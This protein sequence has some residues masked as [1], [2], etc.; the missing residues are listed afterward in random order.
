MPLRFLFGPVTTA[1]AEENL[2][3]FRE[4]GTC[5]AFGPAGTSDISI[6]PGE[7]WDAVLA[8]LPESWRP[9]FVALWLPYATIP[10]GL[11]SAPVPLVGLAADW[12]L[13]WHQYRRCLRRC[14]LVLTDAAGVDVMRRAGIT[15]VRAADLFGCE[16]S[17]LE[18]SLLDGPRDIDIL[19]VGNV[20]SAV[21][22][23]RLAWLG[24]LARLSERRRVAI[25]TSIH[26]ADYRALLRRAK[27]VFNRSIRGECNR[28]VFEAAAS[29]ALLFQEAGNREV[30]AY[31]RDRQE[32]VYYDEGNLEALLEHYLAH[33]DERL[34]IAAAAREK[35]Q[36]FRFEDFW[37]ATLGRVEEDW[38]EVA[39]RS[40]QRPAFTDIEDV[41]DRTWQCLNSG[42]PAADPTL[43]RDLAAALT[44]H[45][46]LAALHN[47]LGLVVAQSAQGQGPITPAVAEQAVGY[48][49]RAVSCNPGHV[50]A[51]LNVAEALLGIG[52][53]EEAV[54]QARKTLSALE[55]SQNLDAS[56]LDSG[57]FPP[58]FDPFR[59]EWERAAWLN[60]G[61]PAEEERAKRDLLRW[62]LNLLLTGLTG[63][64]THAFEAVLARPDLPSSRVEL[65]A[66]LAQ[67]GRT[68]EALPHLRAAV[69]ANPFDVPAARALFQALGDAED[70]H[71]QRFLARDRR[72]LAQA[73]PQ[74]V[75]PEPWFMN[76]PPVGDEL[77]SILILCCNEVEY[78]RQCLESVFRHT[79]RPY[80]LILVDNGSSDRTP[81]YLDEVS[82][83][84]GPDRV[85]VLRNDTNRGFPAGCNQ[86]LAQVQGRYV[87]FLN[88]DTIVTE[89]WLDGLIRWSLNEWPKIGLVG[90]VTNYAP[91]PQHVGEDPG[92]LDVLPA[93]A[94]RRQR[95]YAG[96][97]LE[98]ERLSGFCLLARR[99][100]LQQIGGFDERFGLGFFDD[101]D[102][103]VRVRQGGYRLLAALNV[104]IHHFGSR[105]FT[106]LGLD[107]RK[108]L[109]E[110][111]ERFKA[112]WGPERAAGYLLP[113]EAVTK[114]ESRVS[115]HENEEKRVPS[116]NGTGAAEEPSGVPVTSGG[117]PRVSLCVIVKNEEGNLPDCLGSAADL[118]DEVV[119]VDTGSTDDT[120]Q[121]AARFGAKVVDF[122]W[123][124]SFAAARNESLKH[125]TGSWIFWLDADDR[126]DED[127][128]AKLRS[129]FTNL[130]GDN[131]AFAMKCL[132]LPDPITGSTTVVDHVRL[133]PNRP[134]VRWKY[135]VHEQILP[136]LRS[137]G[138]QIRWAN[139]VINHA[140]YQ[141]PALRRR[142][143]DRDLRLLELENAEHPDDPF[144]LFNLGSVFQE[145]GQPAR[146]L[147]MLQRSLERSQPRDSIVRKLFALIV[148]CHRRL[149]Q[150]D[151]A[152]AAC[153]TGRGHYPEDAELLFLEALVQREQGNKEGAEASLLKLIEE[154]EGAH[155]ASVDAGL[156]GYKARHNLAVIYQEEGRLPEAEAQ[157]TSVVRDQPSFLPAVLGMGELFLAQQRWADFEGVVKH[158]QEVPQ[159]SVE[160]AV[161]QARGHLVRREFVLARLL[162]RET[163]AQFPQALWPRVILSHVLLQEGRDWEA[164][165]QALR[166]VLELAPNHTEARRNLDILLQQRNE[167]NGKPLANG[168][169]LPSPT[170]PTLAN[171][172][173]A[174]C[175]TP[176]D[177][178]EH[179][180]TLHALAKE[181]RHVTEFGTRTGISTTA[182]LL[183]QPETLVCY[184]L[185][186]FPQV[187]RLSELAGRVR[188]VF[189]QADVRTVAIEETDLLFIDSWHVYRQLQEE[190]RLH[191]AKVR[192]YLVLHDTTTYAEK[193]E[194]DGHRGLWPAVEEF[195]AKRTFRI[196]QRF[197]N[198]NGL[199]VLERVQPG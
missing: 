108:Q 104:Y 106:G 143:L 30:P 105:T 54:T 118:V 123:V 174:A 187:D 185:R 191:A 130:N 81:A 43:T 27:I 163:I 126:V 9:D 116:V 73:A 180:P 29:G 41:C 129:L 169:L 76:C 195:L 80:E 117:R 74:I 145:L 98:V 86:G 114:Q 57:H 5:L 164:A 125:A 4:T 2:R 144:T 63:D 155:F 26:G 3:R 183:A 110:N 47:A 134:D 89:G 162:L 95:E 61:R 152:V 103:C 69:A 52:K 176:S 158:L 173:Q 6:A 36:G 170:A 20:S 165:E 56:V 48:F 35:V 7:T 90:A 178:H 39:E 28:R 167:R 194:T 70:G 83:R 150:P 157:W 60:A 40:R 179:L 55:R 168:Q 50:M 177:I 193:G 87:V 132:C 175:S 148:Q 151:Q 16:S 192:K 72:L 189:H 159:G 45:P 115:G 92:D 102:L 58:V 91:A 85:V 51:G 67:V 184:D 135:R 141:D 17:F 100:V 156:R 25:L 122:P 136:A 121:V 107:S 96:K 44:R 49:R 188:F 37:G 15:H 65:G 38:E 109:E 127:N 124:D 160:A 199:T 172:Y 120:K 149:G 32:C 97:A 182:L 59:V 14:D 186:R 139:V 71:G 23:E 42:G 146:A 10:V 24:R 161:M 181:C 19:F 31:F 82:T 22:R 138:G 62:R 154:R 153:R 196:K 137:I 133:F 18:K 68:T 93:F 111:F 101:D 8:K 1:F 84:A 12:N 11:W 79:R 147:P 88:N 78:T 99:E 46:R 112:K 166:D 66:A 198:N 128:R 131:V 13:L 33:E 34:A 94:A 142:K 197:E 119:V 140:G 64:V 53:K 75:S 77:A 21:Q 113:E 171:L 190:L